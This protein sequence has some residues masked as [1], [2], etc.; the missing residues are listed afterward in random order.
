[1]LHL[2]GEYAP[3]S[4]SAQPPAPNAKPVNARLEGQSGTCC[5]LKIVRT[6]GL[7]GRRKAVPILRTSGEFGGNEDWAAEGHGRLQGQG[8][9]KAG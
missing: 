4:P 1:M 3:Q 7:F 8:V 2:G 9:R 6:F 5:R